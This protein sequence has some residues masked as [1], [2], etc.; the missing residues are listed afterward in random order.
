MAHEL[1]H[2]RQWIDYREFD[3]IEAEIG[4]SDLVEDYL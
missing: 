3:E 1:V 4:A 2:Y